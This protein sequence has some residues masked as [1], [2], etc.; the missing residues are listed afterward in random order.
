LLSMS[1]TA[2]LIFATSLSLANP[3]KLG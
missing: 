2:L 1:T 3:S